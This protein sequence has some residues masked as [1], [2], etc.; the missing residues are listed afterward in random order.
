MKG[1]RVLL[2]WLAAGVLAIAYHLF[3]SAPARAELDRG[4]SHSL[5]DKRWSDLHGLELQIQSQS[6]SGAEAAAARR[7]RERMDQEVEALRG[8]VYGRDG[9]PGLSAAL[10]VNLPSPSPMAPDLLLKFQRQY[11]D[12]LERLWQRLKDGGVAF[13]GSAFELEEPGDEKLN[14]ANYIRSSHLEKRFRIV[15]TLCGFFA[16]ERVRRVRF[17]HFNLRPDAAADRYRIPRGERARA[18]EVDAQFEIPWANLPLFLRDVLTPTGG[19]VFTVR[20][21]SVERL[22]GGSA[23]GEKA[24]PAVQVRVVLWA[25]E[26]PPEAVPAEPA[27]A[28]TEGGG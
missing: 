5:A 11:T 12:S 3:A 27:P 10:R 22:E 4:V 15:D 6:R 7:A 20:R 14:D 18:F 16:A 26:F 28:K 23:P 9:R 8:I 24:V 21:L 13:D 2:A 1:D 19:I 25:L 17:V